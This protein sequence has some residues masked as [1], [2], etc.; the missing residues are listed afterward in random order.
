[1]YYEGLIG[2]YVTD[3]VRFHQYHVELVSTLLHR[4]QDDP[5]P[6]RA[7]PADRRM[8]QYRELRHIVVELLH[9][10]PEGRWISRLLLQAVFHCEHQFRVCRDSSFLSLSGVLDSRNLHIKQRRGL[11]VLRKCLHS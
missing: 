11:V 5:L 2:P 1:M 9:G 6:S 3:L 8:E 10:N 7:A 4:E